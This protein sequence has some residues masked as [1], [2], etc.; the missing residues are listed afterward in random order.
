MNILI[1]GSTGFIGSNLV[2]KLQVFDHKLYLL[3]RSS[4]SISRL[5]NLQKNV[6]FLSIDS[7]SDLPKIFEKYHFDII[8]HLATYYIRNEKSLGDKETMNATNITFPSLLLNLAVKNGV[9][10]FINTGTCFEYK[11][12]TKKLVETDLLE[13]YNYYAATKIAFEKILKY[14]AK[15][16]FRALTLK[17]FF[18]YGEKDNEKLIPLLIKSFIHSKSFNLTKGEQRLNFTYVGD[19]INAYIKALAFI[20][21]DDYK[22]YEVFNV[23]S[24]NTYSPKEIVGMLEKISK[25]KIDI[26]FDTPYPKNEIMY[27]VCNSEKAKKILGWQPQTNLFEG[28][29]KVYA[30]Y[31]K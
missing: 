8:M 11:P 19:I 1:T 2:E 25:R 28:L 16:D 29:K 21:S 26:L 7:Y 20:T 30:F 6:S 24:A 22:K 3:K 10:A 27:M 15:S 18:P 13:P 12:S 9:K 5:E 23:G 31:N 14:Y 17:L 4:P